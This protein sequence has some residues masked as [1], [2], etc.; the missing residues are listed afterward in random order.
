MLH[1]VTIV[2]FTSVYV[3]LGGGDPAVTYKHEDVFPA[4]RIESELDG[5]GFY[6]ESR[7]QP[8]PAALG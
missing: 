1:Q 2:C 4:W 7:S 5:F 6:T 3:N 8:H